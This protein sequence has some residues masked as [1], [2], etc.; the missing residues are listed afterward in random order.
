RLALARTLLRRPG[1]YLF[2]DCFSGL[3]AA[4]DLAVRSAL[5]PELAD[6]TVVIVAQRVG[7]IRNADLILVLEDG[8]V[9]GRG[10]H[11]QLLTENGTYQEIVRSQLDNAEEAV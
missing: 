7:T 6:A 11:D 1:I 8:R 10:T 4:T 3:D 9:V 5:A 2:D